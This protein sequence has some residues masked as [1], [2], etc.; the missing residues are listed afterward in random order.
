MFCD[1]YREREGEGQTAEQLLLFA[2]ERLEFMERCRSSLN[3][4]I[5]RL[6]SLNQKFSAA[7]SEAICHQDRRLYS[8]GEAY[9]SRP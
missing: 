6:L 9:V 2:W 3:D 4:E 7:V 1:E 8:G 5:D